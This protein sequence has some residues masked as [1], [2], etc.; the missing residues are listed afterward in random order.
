MHMAAHGCSLKGHGH[1][2]TSHMLP[3]MVV[4]TVAAAAAATPLAVPSPYNGMFTCLPTTSS[5][6]MTSSTGSVQVGAGGCL[7][8]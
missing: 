7:E 5:V 6:V 1:G 3:G 4:L 8:G 2:H